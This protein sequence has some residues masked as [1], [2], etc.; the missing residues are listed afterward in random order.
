MNEFEYVKH[1]SKEKKETQ[2]GIGRCEVHGCPMPGHI[3]TGN[4]NCRYHFG[5]EGES[6]GRI[7]AI[8]KNHPK[9][10][11]WYE[12]ILSG[13]L[14]DF[15]MGK[16]HGQEPRGFEIGQMESFA[17]Y[18]KRIE[19]KISNKLRGFEKPEQAKVISKGYADFLKFKE[20]GFKL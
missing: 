2:S 7:T 13:P 10:F 17:H 6:L 3:K 20:L 9:E 12:T 5:K 4:W 8:L 15:E 16:L 1:E 14:V 18:K 19:A 11:D